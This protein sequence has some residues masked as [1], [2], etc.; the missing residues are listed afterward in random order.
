MHEAF[1]P[2]LFPWSSESVDDGP[3]VDI[4]ANGQRA[5]TSKDEHTLLSILRETYRSDI[6]TPVLPYDPDALLSA[7]RK[8]AFTPA[9]VAEIRRLTM[10]WHLSAFATPAQLARKT[11]EL[12][13]VAALL[14]AGVGRPGRKERLDF[15]LMHVLTSTVFVP[16]LVGAL[17]GAAAQKRLLEAVLS[18]VLAYML[19]RGRPRIDCELIMSYTASP[20]PDGAQLMPT[21]GALGE[22]ATKPDEYIN[23]WPTLL[24]HVLPARDAHTLKALRTLYVGAQR[25]GTIPVGA[26]RGAVDGR[27]EETHAGA[28]GLDGSVFVRAAGA[29]AR[30]MGW[31]GPGEGGGQK[32]GSWDRSAL[33]WDEAWDEED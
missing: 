13:F 21:P 10:L 25:Y 27:G 29:L 18:V 28:K 14:F 5:A 15:F 19:L 16:N 23:P 1:E 12:F 6:M 11:E 26:V 30:V 22:P 3:A 17:D 2:G 7:R 32:E 9:R 24:A 20:R 4:S 31:V 33:G 8:A